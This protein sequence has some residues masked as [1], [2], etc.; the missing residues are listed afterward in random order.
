MEVAQAFKDYEEL[1][2][3]PDVPIVPKDKTPSPSSESPVQV[4]PPHTLH[5][6]TAPT[7]DVPTDLS[8]V[9]PMRPR[10][11]SPTTERRSSSYNDKYAAIAMPPLREETPT[12]SPAGTLSRGAKDT[13]V[14]DNASVLG[15]RK[16]RTDPEQSVSTPTP[17]KHAQVSEVHFGMVILNEPSH[18]ADDHF[19]G[20]Q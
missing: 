6:A 12:S 9:S 10:V 2:A 17:E 14:N 13:P 8:P 7:V 15:V 5:A 4:T 1:S 18:R 11:A 20:F 3:S 16:S 19:G